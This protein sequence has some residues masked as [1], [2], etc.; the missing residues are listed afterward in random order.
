MTLGTTM[1]YLE[2]LEY[3]QVQT[4]DGRYLSSEV[5]KLEDEQGWLDARADML[6]GSK[7]AQ[8]FGLSPWTD[9]EEDRPPSLTRRMLCGSLM[10]GAMAG[11]PDLQKQWQNLWP[12][13]NGFVWNA[14]DWLYEHLEYDYVGATPDVLVM[15]Q[16]RVIGV[17]ELKFQQSQ[18][19]YEYPPLHY[20]LQA[21]LTA[22]VMGAPSYA[23]SCWYPSVGTFWFQTLPL[24]APL[25]GQDKPYL[26]ADY[27]TPDGQYSIKDLLELWTDK[28]LSGDKWPQ[29]EGISFNDDDEM[30]MEADPEIEGLIKEYNRI[31]IEHNATGKARKVL[32]D[33]IV[34]MCHNI[35]K[36]DTRILDAKTSDQLATIK[37]TQQYRFHDRNFEEDYP[38]FHSKY[39]WPV[40]RTTLKVSLPAE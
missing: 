38:D 31:N 28:T 9:L 33:K 12:D 29:M 40:D 4:Y 36:K 11:D 25:V 26:T 19:S 21:A 37:T 2:T 3:S 23:L 15:K 34:E 16:G 27:R 35:D 7:A 20:L 1:P 17:V 13:A 39:Y 18:W 32:R 10:E 5:S 22:D 30:L 8:Q 14:E 24:Y 6:T